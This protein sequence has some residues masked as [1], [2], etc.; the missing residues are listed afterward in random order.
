MVFLEKAPVRN[1]AGHFIPKIFDP[2][3]QPHTMDQVEKSGVE[4][5]CNPYR[6]FQPQRTENFTI[7]KSL[8]KISGMNILE[9]E[10]LGIKAVEGYGT[11]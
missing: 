8:L 4:M 6:T 10:S 11:I 9:L 5:T 3:L 2:K 7:E 1:V